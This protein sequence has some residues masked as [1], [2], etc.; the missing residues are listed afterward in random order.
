MI[1]VLKYLVTY[2]VRLFRY[3]FCLIKSITAES[4]W[5][6]LSVQFLLPAREFEHRL[7]TASCCKTFSEGWFVASGDYFRLCRNGY[8][9]AS[10]MP[11]NSL[12]MQVKKFFE[13]HLAIIGY[14]VWQSRS[15]YNWHLARDWTRN[16]KQQWV[17]HSYTAT[18]FTHPSHRSSTAKKWTNLQPLPFLCY[19]SSYSYKVHF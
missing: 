4:G 3:L 16:S 15:W 17:H 8:H 1:F 9:H 2:L 19:G 7:C 10:N 18:Y 6:P 12:Y 13:R 5:W 11:Y 14:L